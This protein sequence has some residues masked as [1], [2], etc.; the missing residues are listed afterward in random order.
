MNKIAFSYLFKVL[1][2]TSPDF[3]NQLIASLSEEE[4]LTLQNNIELASKHHIECKII[5]MYI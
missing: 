5:K 2:Q 4:K 1:Q 3:Y